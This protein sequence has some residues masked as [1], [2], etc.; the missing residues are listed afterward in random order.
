MSILIAALVVFMIVKMLQGAGDAVELA[1]GGTRATAKGAIK[2]GRS[3]DAGAMALPCGCVAKY[4]SNGQ[5]TVH[6]STVR[7]PGHLREER[8]ARAAES[9][10]RGY[11][12]RG[13]KGA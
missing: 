10:F 6:T 1:V 3:V 13:K 11:G 4:K 12:P 2:K 8:A 5:Y 9:G 7:C